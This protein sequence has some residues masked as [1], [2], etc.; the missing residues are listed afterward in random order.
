MDHHS[1]YASLLKYL[2]SGT[3]LILESYVNEFE[4]FALFA[5]ALS[6]LAGNAG[7]IFVSRISTSLHSSSKEHYLVVS[8]ALFCITC[9]VLFL[10]LLFAWSTGQ[11]PVTLVFALAFIFV[12]CVEVWSP[13]FNFPSSSH[14]F[15]S[16]SRL[17]SH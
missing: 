10:F 17:R 7:S 9:P 4:G 12:V 11:V 2:L 14:Q 5:P 8:A 1:S 16:K 15:P 3:G 6:S 13:S